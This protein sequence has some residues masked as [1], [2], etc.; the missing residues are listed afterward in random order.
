MFMCA[1]YCD[2][3]LN[4]LSQG[5]QENVFGSELACC[6]SFTPPKS[7]DPAG[8]TGQR[9]ETLPYVRRICPATSTWDP[10]VEWERCKEARSG[11]R[12]GR[13]GFWVHTRRRSQATRHA[14]NGAVGAHRAC[15]RWLL[16]PRHGGHSCNLVPR[17]TKIPSAPGTSP[18]AP[19]PACTSLRPPAPGMRF[20]SYRTRGPVGRSAPASLRPSPFH[21]TAVTCSNSDG[22]LLTP[23]PGF[24]GRK[25]GGGGEYWVNFQ[26]WTL[27]VDQKMTFGKGFSQPAALGVFSIA[28]ASQAAGSNCTPW[29]CWET[30]VCL[31]SRSQAWRELPPGL[32]GLRRGDHYSLGLLR[33]HFS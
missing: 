23:P 19:P 11:F 18:L 22:D 2:C 24:P 5:S 33:P 26:K 16:E 3:C 20:R 4:S 25:F 10:P 17:T 7:A 27:K 6:T 8:G 28:F 13:R 30:P 14:A 31:W 15:V 9:V 21:Y 29:C 12:M 32:S 1:S